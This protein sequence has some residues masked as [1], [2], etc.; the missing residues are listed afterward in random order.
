M[1]SLALIVS[2]H[3]ARAVW[4]L[5]LLLCPVS[6]TMAFAQNASSDWFEERS[7]QDVRRVSPAALG[8]LA[9]GERLLNSGQAAQAEKAFERAAA[10]VPDNALIMRRQCEALTSLKQP[11]AAIKAC[12]QAMNARGRGAGEMVAFVHASVAAAFAPTPDNLYQAILMT[13]A[14][15][16]L[17]PNQAFPYAAQCEIAEQQHD[18]AFMEKCAAQIQRSAPNSPY[19]KR[20][21]RAVRESRPSWLVWALW[22]AVLA[23]VLVTLLH[24]LRSAMLRVRAKSRIRIGVPGAALIIILSVLSGRASAQPIVAPKI[25]SKQPPAAGKLQ[26]NDADPVSSVPTPE[27]RDSN[28]VGYAYFI[29]DL[30]SRAEKAVRLDDH[31]AAVKY[32]SALA[33]AVPDRSIAYTRLC[34]SYEALG[35][36]KQALDS[37]RAALGLAGVTDQDYRNYADL[38]VRRKP[39]FGKAD[40]TD[41]DEIVKHLR[42]NLPDNSVADEV[43]C[44]L[45]L[46][47]KDRMRVQRC[48]QNLAARWPNN[49]KTLTYQWAFAVMRNDYSAASQLLEKLKKTNPK[50]E[51]MRNMV[52]MTAQTAQPWWQR[53]LSNSW[54]AALFVLVLL[55]LGYA[56]ARFKRTRHSAQA[57]LAEGS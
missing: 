26:I 42:Q 31:Q 14:L 10:L 29:M 23:V 44:E 19:A 4:L 6:E 9:Q 22:H 53:A 37:C 24:L 28:P 43:E 45:G 13:Q 40:V 7:L 18:W 38:V 12:Q 1:S 54:A 35:D 57:R 33:K 47:V 36:W 11:A 49:Q 25:E 8:L 41:L 55:T 20:F 21:Q 15:T 39:N 27:Q 46:K 17:V 48:T 56:V 32:F 34:S 52:E 30:T 50:P 5:V 3:P 2:R 16:R 51:V